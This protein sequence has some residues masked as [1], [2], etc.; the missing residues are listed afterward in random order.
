MWIFRKGIQFIHYLLV[1]KTPS[2]VHSPFLF[3]LL[4]LIHDTERHYYVFNEIEE[5]RRELLNNN[6][7]IEPMDFGAGSKVKHRRTLADIAKTSLTPTARCQILFR[8]ITYQKPR[9]ILELGTSLGITTAYLAA[10]SQES[11]V[12]TI[13]GNPALSALAASVAEQ[14]SLKNIS[15]HTGK[16]TDVLPVLLKKIPPPELIL[17]DGDHRGEALLS[18]YQMMKG[19]F[20]THTV[21]VVDDIRWSEDMY[22]AWETLQADKDVTCALDCFSFGMLFF[23]NEFKDTVRLMIRAQ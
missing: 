1:A 20:L 18:Y 23:R 4:P 13:E 15:F 6:Q 5:I 9:T 7:R 2:Q 21:I 3:E 19:R 22:A 11:S 16:F 12:Y 14:L 8:L 17:I 10:A